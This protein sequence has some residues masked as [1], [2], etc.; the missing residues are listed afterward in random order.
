MGG[1]FGL[2][3]VAIGAFGAHA[4]KGVLTANDTTAT[5]QTGV[6]YH[7]MHALAL[8]LVGALYNQLRPNKQL[9]LIGWLFTVGILLFSGS[10]YALAVTNIKIFGAIT[11]LGGVCFLAGWFL[12]ILTA[13]Q[14]QDRGNNHDVTDY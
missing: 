4:L 12:I 14:S 7:M 3:G 11:P 10:L 6:Q 9:R 5:F 2:L 8:L 1:I 13:A